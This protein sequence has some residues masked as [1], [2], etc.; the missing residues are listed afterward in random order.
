MVEDERFRIVYD[1][2]YAPV[3]R[4]AFRRVPADAVEDI[5]SE[6]FVVAWRRRSELPPEPLPWLY[7]VARKTIANYERGRRRRGQLDDQLQRNAAAAHSSDASV[8]EGM[9]ITWALRQLSERDREVLRLTAWEGLD[10]RSTAVVLECSAP[11]ASVR[12]H[13]AR[14]RLQRLLQ[15]A[16]APRGDIPPRPRAHKTTSE[17]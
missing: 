2:C 16:D 11:T 6:V 13:R 9:H 8:V 5:T 4:Y 7:G 10:I 1:A 15:S 3:L 12:L 14:R 17:V